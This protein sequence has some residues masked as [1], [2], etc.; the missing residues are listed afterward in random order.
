MFTDLFFPS[1]SHHNKQSSF[2]LL[3]R[4]K[5]EDKFLEALV[6]CSAMSARDDAG[7]FEDKN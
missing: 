7:V 3:S 2:L 1:Y 6:A 4:G 5:T